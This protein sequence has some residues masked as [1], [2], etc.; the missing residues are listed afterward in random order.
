ME[1]CGKIVMHCGNL[2]EYLEIG[3][4][5]L[6]REFVEFSVE[7]RLWNPDQS[8]IGKD[9]NKSENEGNKV[10]YEVL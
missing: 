5:K 10:M 3:K 4:Y 2:E 7:S 8:L 1:H 9:G 6:L